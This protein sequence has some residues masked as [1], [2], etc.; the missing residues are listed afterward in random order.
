MIEVFLNGLIVSSIFL[1]GLL[2]MICISRPVLRRL[3]GAQW[4]YASWLFL[5]LPI[6]LQLIPKPGWPAG[7][8]D[9]W[10]SDGIGLFSRV[11]ESF[12]LFAPAALLIWF[13]GFAVSCWISASR[14]RALYATIKVNSRPV[15]EA[16]TAAFRDTCEKLRVFPAPRFLASSALSSPALIGIASPTVAVPEDFFERFS[17]AERDLMLRHELT[18]IIRRDLLRNLMFETIRCSFWFL[19]ILRYVERAFRTDQELACDCAV[20]WDEPNAVRADY[21][22]A[23]TK[24]TCSAA[25]RTLFPQFK[26]STK[27]VLQRA[28]AVKLH[29]A[30]PIRGA[31][32]FLT[33]A[34]LATGVVL[35]TPGLTPG[36]KFLQNP[37]GWCAFR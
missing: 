24:V 8:I 7:F 26:T 21:V 2:T 29:R 34:L 10:F 23:L 28:V 20:L 3:G 22:V 18:H 31:L 35:A 27:Q 25:D 14:H 17:P 11:L 5:P 19:P 16:A 36:D 1:I 32:C 37:S 9:D 6:V 30:R 33:L 12:P 4:A 13:V 15:S